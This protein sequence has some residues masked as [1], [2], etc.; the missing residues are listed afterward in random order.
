M[1]TAGFF[2]LTTSGSP[3]P[4]PQAKRRM[5]NVKAPNDLQKFEKIEEVRMMVLLFFYGCVCGLG[6]N[7]RSDHF[8]ISL[9]GINR[10]MSIVDRRDFNAILA[11]TG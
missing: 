11:V 2:G 8:K 3:L 6:K 4:P 1:M 10:E 5:V 7:Q 9:R